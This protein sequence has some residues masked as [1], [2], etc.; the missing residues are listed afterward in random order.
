M[1]LNFV[2]HGCPCTDTTQNIE[3]IIT[4]QRWSGYA[5]DYARIQRDCITLYR[6]AEKALH[7]K[8]LSRNNRKILTNF[9]KVMYE[10][11]PQIER[12]GHRPPLED[13]EDGIDTSSPEWCGVYLVGAT[14]FNPFTHEEFYWVKNG[15][16]K[17]IAKRM[18]QYDTCNPMTFHIDFKKC[19]SEKE[20]YLVEDIY[21]EKL[22][23]I[24]LNSCAKNDE[25]FRVSRETYLAICAG[26]YNYLDDV[27][28]PID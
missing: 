26:G 14:H 9:L 25:W 8:G 28:Y 12:Y 27:A 20:A 16:A 19:G 5:E 4:R 24:A 17:N 18:S 23:T 3:K 10:N 2:L 1:E 11:F 22:K 21:K 6:A 7:T 13:F 15:K